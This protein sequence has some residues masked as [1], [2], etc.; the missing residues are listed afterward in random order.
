MPTRLP[1][2]RSAL[3]DRPE[4]LVRQGEIVKNILAETGKQGAFLKRLDSR[5]RRN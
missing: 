2:G 4:V 3:P 5:T 1:G